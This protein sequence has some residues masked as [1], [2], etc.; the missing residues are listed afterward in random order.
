MTS[1][2]AAEPGPV[3]VVVFDGDCG[4]CASSV[5]AACRWVRPQ[6]VFTPWQ[7]ADLGALGLSAADCQ[8]AVQ[9]VA[10]DGTVTSGGQAVLRVL[11]LGRSPW[12]RVASATDRVPGAGRAVGWVYRVVARHRHRLPG[13]TAACAIRTSQAPGAGA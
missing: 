3:A 8:E 10:G 11:A 4:F 1:A 6:A 13:G 9:L 12:P 7:S 5:R 2:Q